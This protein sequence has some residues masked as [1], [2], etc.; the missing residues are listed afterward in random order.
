L[1]DAALIMAAVLCMLLVH[2]LVMW[3]RD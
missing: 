3:V 1:P 2:Q